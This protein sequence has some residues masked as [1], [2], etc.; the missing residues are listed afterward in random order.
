MTGQKQILTELKSK[1]TGDLSPVILSP[2]GKQALLT[3]VF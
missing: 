2:E 1:L 3:P